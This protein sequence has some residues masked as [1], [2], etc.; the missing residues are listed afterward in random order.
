LAILSPRADGCW[1]CIRFLDALTE[2]APVTRAAGPVDRNHPTE[3]IER[4]MEAAF[5]AFAAHGY[6]GASTRQIAK[7]AQ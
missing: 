1:E 7:E 2:T 3:L 6:E 5:D 4:L